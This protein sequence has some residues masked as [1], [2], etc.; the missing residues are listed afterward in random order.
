MERINIAIDGPSGSGKSTIAKALAE[1][2]NLAYLDT[3]AMYRGIGYYLDKCG[4][5]VNN[6]KD[7]VNKLPTISMDILYDKNKQIVIVNNED[8]TPFIRQNKVS[9]LASN[10]SKIRESLPSILFPVANLNRA[11][12]TAFFIYR[13]CFKSISSIISSNL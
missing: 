6:V 10:V 1:K 11:R 3:G 5:D 2:L 4:I 13:E 8:V 7:V 12:I 9:I